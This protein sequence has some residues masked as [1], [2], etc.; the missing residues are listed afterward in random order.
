MNKFKDLPKP[1]EPIVV[2][3]VFDEKDGVERYKGVSVEEL[4]KGPVEETVWVLWTGKK[5]NKVQAE[6]AR[7]ILVMAADH[8]PEVAG[9]YSTI[10]AASAGLNLP[11]AVAA[12]VQM[13]GPR[14]GGASGQA[15][16]NF[17]Y[18][19]DNNLS[20]SDFEKWMKGRGVSVFPG[21]GH[22]VFSKSKPD[23]RVLNLIKFAKSNLKDMKHLNFAL[24]L[25]QETLKKNDKLI[26]NI[27][28]TIGAILMDVGFPAV[29]VDGFF[30][31]SR[32]IGLIAHFIDQKQR[33]TGLIRL[34]E[35]FVLHK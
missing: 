24:K 9:A 26:L 8:G 15:A 34:P 2:T 12:G 31:L 29:G 1:I 11:Q 32:T 14:F 35:N 20:V 19:V 5:P 21:I 17:K 6:L 7:T 27:D 23:K 13:V 30:V 4:L 16:E 28:G 33:G 25:E 22:R 18:A 3:T 10:L